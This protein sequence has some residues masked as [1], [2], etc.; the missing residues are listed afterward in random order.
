MSR[1]VLGTAGHID[2][3]KTAL[4]RALTGIDTDRLKV[5]KERGIT[6]ELG[7][8]HLELDGQRFGFVDVPGH[9]R[10]V[11]SMV[12]G[13]TGIDLVCLVI[14]ADEGVMPQTREHLDICG[15]LGVRAGLVA[16][17]KSDLVD[18]DWLKLVT[19]DIAKTLE[20][21]FLGGVAIV[22]CSAKT[23]AGLDQ[24]RH[25]LATLAQALPPRTAHGVF[26][27]PIDRSFTMKGFG[28][29]AT[30]TIASGAVCV[31]DEVTIMPGEQSAKVRGLQV[32]GNAV[33][34]AEAGCRCAM[35]L[36][37]VHTRDIHRG[38]VV[39]HPSRVAPSH[40]IDVELRYLAT[41][42]EPLRTRQRVIIH[43]GTTQVLGSV[44]LLDSEALAPGEKGLAQLRIDRETPVAAVPGDHFLLRGF[45]AQKHYGTT[46][47]GGTILRVQA[48]KL[49][50]RDTETGELDHLRVASE[51][52][53]L[54]H[55]AKR[56]SHRGL[57]REE[58]GQRIGLGEKE[59]DRRLAAVIEGGEI[60]VAKHAEG[61][62]VLIAPEI[63]A[64]LEQR[65]E[66]LIDE[67]EGGMP[68]GEVREKLPHNMPAAV[69]E[70]IVR[71]L[72]DRERIVMKDGQLCRPG[73]DEPV[74]LSS[75]A[76]TL[77][78]LFL[79]WGATPPRPAELAASSEL[80]T[81]NAKRA[82]A[83]LLEAGRLTKVK[84]DLFV[85]SDVIADLR[86]KLE[87]H[88]DAHGEISPAQW[89]VITGASRKYSIPLAEH[90]DQERIT[91]RVGNAR[92]RRG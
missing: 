55:E 87:A 59:L 27:L 67:A 19:T 35:N 33:E 14:A 53:L 43:H 77:D 45:V 34:R 9:E 25:E 23:G 15:L 73:A 7:F 79:E 64:R 76:L 89:K 60:V 57:S 16:L 68:K 66:T 22:P 62:E 90:F 48:A 88:L 65:I 24:I 44:T 54:I 30:G 81:D 26:R 1:V 4:V 82:A 21:T 18:D 11:R 42:V 28:S 6:T 10:F 63:I 83:S 75:D 39:T 13:A 38:D 71:D 17:T 84:S 31:G 29:V 52:D 47:G 46:I 51:R 49:R 3:G 69:F 5:E 20:D 50:A 72:S 86:S 78:R 85:H 91:L 61:S 36:G 74:A 40:I 32:H 56:A 70:L 41:S 80:S 92:K 37:G 12:S 2:H 8:A 58:L